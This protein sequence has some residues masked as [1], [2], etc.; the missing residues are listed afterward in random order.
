MARKV[1]KSDPFDV[2]GAPPKVLKLTERQQDFM[3]G[4]I[5]SV[6]ERTYRIAF[7][8]GVAHAFSMV[9]ETVAR[10][11]RSQQSKLLKSK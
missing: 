4:H 3:R 6:V 2:W 8:N 9:S 7:D 11:W 5:E 10:E 1:T